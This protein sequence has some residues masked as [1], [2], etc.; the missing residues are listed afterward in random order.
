[1]YLVK[2]FIE[3]S[4]KKMI[5]FFILFGGSGSE[6]SLCKKLERTFISCELNKQ[7]YDMIIDRINNN[8]KIKD[9]YAVYDAK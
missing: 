1:M 6:I 9:C 4:T 3:S 2:L 5:L 7:Y 8:G